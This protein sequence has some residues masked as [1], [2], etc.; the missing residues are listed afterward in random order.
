M[1]LESLK[2]F[3]GKY[4]K[5]ALVSNKYFTFIQIPKTSS[6]TVFCCC[7]QMGLIKKRVN[8]CHHE[9]LLYL[10]NIIDTSLPVYAIVRNPFSHIHSYFFHQIK[11]KELKLDPK[12]SIISNFEN[13]VRKEINNVHLQQCRYL[14]SN[15][16][17]KVKIF[18]MENNDFNDYLIQTHNLDLDLNNC[19]LNYNPKKN[20]QIPL[21]SFFRD[22]EIVNLIVKERHT[23]FKEFGYSIDPNDLLENKELE[24][25]EALE[26][27]F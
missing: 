16:G 27:G 23:E 2:I 10:E 5:R 24:K 14:E 20:R 3:R 18:K 6:T 19:V 26:I 8:C 15:R 4:K 22:P 11:M 25:Q 12:L 9:G 21:I 1:D 17:I 13:F 7:R